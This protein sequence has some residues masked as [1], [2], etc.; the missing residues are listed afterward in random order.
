MN[1]AVDRTIPAFFAMFFITIDA[2]TNIA[3]L[4]ANA[5]S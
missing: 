3:C 1:A 4:P 5:E 2:Q